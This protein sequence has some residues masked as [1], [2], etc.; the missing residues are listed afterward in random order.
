MGSSALMVKMRY[1]ADVE[2]QVDEVL[3]LVA[4]MVKMRHN[5]DG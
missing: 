1:K 2:D 3:L 4:L 5:A